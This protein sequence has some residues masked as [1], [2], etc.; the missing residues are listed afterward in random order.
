MR[1]L[2]HKVIFTSGLLL[3]LAISLFFTK[4]RAE[5]TLYKDRTEQDQE[6]TSSRSSEP[7]PLKIK[8][9]SR[10]Q[11]IKTE[12]SDKEIPHRVKLEI[13]ASKVEI[14]N[15]VKTSLLSFSKIKA[16]TPFKNELSKK[17]QALFPEP[18][19]R[20]LYNFILTSSKEIHHSNEEERIRMAALDYLGEVALGRI[21]YEDQN[22]A[23]E[24]VFDLLQLKPDTMIK[25]RTQKQSHIGD[26]MD[27]MAIYTQ[28]EPESALD[29]IHQHKESKLSKH[30]KTAY[31]NGL[32]FL[33]LPLSE[34]K[35][36]R[37]MLAEI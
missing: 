20:P 6:R 14:D 2:N 27:L 4:Q 35:R 11:A 15:K 34:I 3:C 19:L 25:D 7:I 23:Q 32:F 9:Q 12:S 5:K 30:L 22:N 26:K 13:P 28:I 16:T 24:M 31:S 29:Y 33:G 18:I 36:Q 17:A 21:E 8:A 1:F 10:P 37:K